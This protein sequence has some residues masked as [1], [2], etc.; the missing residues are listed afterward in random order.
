MERRAYKGWTKAKKGRYL[1]KMVAA[2]VREFAPVYC[3][4]LKNQKEFRKIKEFKKRDEFIR[5][6]LFPR[7]MP[8]VE[9]LDRYSTKVK[10]ELLRVQP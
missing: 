7:L 10:R 2:G 5:A 9:L 1:V 4:F 6:W 8:K 3:E